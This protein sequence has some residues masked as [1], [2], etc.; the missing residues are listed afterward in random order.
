MRAQPPASSHSIPEHSAPAQS[1]RPA[2]AYAL[3]LP[4]YLLSIMMLVMQAAGVQVN[5]ACARSKG[6]QQLDLSYSPL[7]PGLGALC[8]LRRSR[9]GCQE[10]C[11]SATAPS[12]LSC[13]HCLVCQM[14]QLYSQALQLAGA[15][16]PQCLVAVRRQLSTSNQWCCVGSLATAASTSSFSCCCSCCAICQMQRPAAVSCCTALCHYLHCPI[17]PFHLS[18]PEQGPTSLCHSLHRYHTC[19]V[20]DTAALSAAVC[21]STS[22]ATP[23]Q[24]CVMPVNRFYSRFRD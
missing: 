18:Q 17:I 3:A 1:T 4:A 23:T 19:S 22:V 14:S 9:P 2:T 6:S 13:L 21:S 10:C 20:S 24:S 8:L 16:G 5:D 15:A 11:S 7:P 12:R